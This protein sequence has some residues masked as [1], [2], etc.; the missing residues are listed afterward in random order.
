MSSYITV[1]PA[2]GTWVVR[3]GGA[4]LAESSRALELRE[5]GHE[6][7]I[8]FPRED[9]AMAFL[10]ASTKHTICPHKGDAGYY[11][12]VTEAGTL[13]DA[14]WTYVQPKTDVHGI[15]EML[16]FDPRHATVERI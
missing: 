3:A 14:V 2:E 15:A 16:A 9:V 6:P 7:V 12:I 11:S 1:A 5:E 4:V 10:E 13:P 8:Y